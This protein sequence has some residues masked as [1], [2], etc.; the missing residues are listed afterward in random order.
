MSKLSD[1][2][3]L[4][5]IRGLERRR[6]LLFRDGNI[7]GGA[8]V[9]RKRLDY[10]AE[11]GERA[12]TGQLDRYVAGQVSLDSTKP[13]KETGQS[14]GQREVMDIKKNALQIAGEQVGA[15]PQEAVELGKWIGRRQAFGMIAAKCGAA[16]AQC[17][18]RIKEGGEYK[19][20]G[21]NWEQFCDQHLGI[22]R[23]TA[24]RIIASFEEFGAAYFNLSNVTRISPTTYRLIAGAVDETTIQLDG[25]KIL[26]TKV[27]AA[28]IAE[29]VASLTK[30]IEEKD[31]KLAETKES[32]DKLRAERN[33]LAKA[34]EKARQEFLEYK[35]AQAA[36][37]PNADEDYTTLL[38]A[39]SLFD[40][41][42]A[43]L[44]GIY[45][46]DLSEDNQARYIGL[47]EYMYRQFIQATFDARDKYGVGW[48]MA[49]PAELLALDQVAPNPRNLVTE[50]TDQA[51]K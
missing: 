48:N 2:Q 3:I 43:K 1:H 34:A 33:S 45:K 21:L 47:T 44:A 5:M 4:A 10:L 50:Y 40:L 37:F 49:E 14:P 22:D 12:K 8:K 38:D 29:A 6:D 31:S 20:L 27:N 13:Q 9:E 11:L 35:K 51:K 36:R 46:R 19:T 42:M 15:D 32:A 26:I 23:K 39:Q 16:D 25:E 28:R 17:L 18:K 24:E 30:S 7:R 41:A